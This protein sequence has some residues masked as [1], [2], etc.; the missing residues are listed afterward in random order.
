VAAKGILNFVDTMEIDAGVDGAW[1]GIRVFGGGERLHQI[2]TVPYGNA[3]SD[4][5]FHRE[6]AEAAATFQTGI[7]GA[8]VIV[9]AVRL[10][11]AGSALHNLFS[12]IYGFCYVALW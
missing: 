2:E 8:I 1:V 11:D 7:L 5:F 4:R 6:D 12:A 10:E 3:T 9:I